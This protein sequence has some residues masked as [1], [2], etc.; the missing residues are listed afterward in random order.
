M[1]S[2]NAPTI[3]R[4]AP[5]INCTDFNVNRNTTKNSAKILDDIGPP[6]SRN[7]NTPILLK[8]GQSN[9]ELQALQNYIL[10]IAPQMASYFAK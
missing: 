6:L 10:K 9:T 5:L 1:I 8:H 3:S 7:I 2:A 4:N